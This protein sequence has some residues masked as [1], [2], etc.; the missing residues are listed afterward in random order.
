MPRVRKPPD[1]GDHILGDVR[2]IL[3]NFKNAERSD[4]SQRR[5][6]NRDLEFSIVKTTWN[7]F[8]SEAGRALT[9][10]VE[11]AMKELNK[12]TC[13]AHILANLH[14]SRL[15][16]RGLTIPKLDQQFF[17]S[18]LSAV[19]QAKRKKAV[20]KDVELRE[21]A[22]IY[23]SWRP[24][25]V[26]KPDSTNLSDGFHQNISLQMATNA[27][28]MIELTFY[29]RFRR[30]LRHKY[31]LD[32][33]QAYQHLQTILSK[34]E[35]SGD[36]AIVRTY[37]YMARDVDLKKKPESAIPL[38]YIFSQYARMENDKLEARRVDRKLRAKLIRLFSLL[39]YKNGF[40]AS[41]I[42]ICQSG[43]YNLLRRSGQDVKRE[44][45][46]GQEDVWWK[47]LFD[48]SRFET[49]SRRFAGEILTDAVGVSIVL[50]RPKP[51]NAVKKERKKARQD[52]DK[53][54][55]EFDIDAYDQI[56]GL[57]PGRKDL[58]VATNEDDQTKKCS[59]KEF[60]HCSKYKLS[61]QKNRKWTDRNP[62]VKCAILTLPTKK[63]CDLVTLEKYVRD[64]L[65]KLNMLN[66]FYSR[67]RVRA[68]KFKR[69]RFCQKK[70]NELC[71]SLTAKAGQKTVI[72]YG[73]WS[74]QDSGAIKKCQSGPVKRLESQ[75]KRYCKVV[76]IDEFRTSKLCQRCECQLENARRRVVGKDFRIHS[77]KIHGVLH[78][79]NSDCT[80]MTVNR[81]VNASRNM[82]DLL[83]GGAC[84]AKRPWRFSR[85][86]KNLEDTCC[87]VSL[88]LS[89]GTGHED[90]RKDRV[91]CS[92]TL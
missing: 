10:T 20:I 55:E 6:E 49:R 9:A 53:R 70:L 24:E 44:N 69:F 40:G 84:G 29:H 3:R 36:D 13:E 81:D 92:S 41:H 89:R 64:M 57:D 7:S 35:Y 5:A 88:R 87:K 51:R 46:D 58:F 12:T 79:S 75:L 4:V 76:E 68:L 47:L 66:E 50:K 30:Y 27:S 16:S 52:P 85:M 32:G 31:G 26:P 33:S 71:A 82:R 15:C 22:A 63:T 34:T 86:N 37:K 21:S 39:P 65:P 28:N 11:I 61:V 23:H 38:L 48:V 45:F 77:T 78:C 83:I 56:W 19:S 25:D 91:T 59:M 67:R 80:S 62:E 43:L 8:C 42:K 2:W 90:G 18:C 60:Y 14:I 72:G 17:Y 73:D 54:V 1:P 74:N